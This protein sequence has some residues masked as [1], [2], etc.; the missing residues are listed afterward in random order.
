MDGRRWLPRP[1]AGWQARN[2]QALFVDTT[3]GLSRSKRSDEQAAYSNSQ[4]RGQLVSL[5]G[6][7]RTGRGMDDCY[8]LLFEAASDCATNAPA[9]KRPMP[10]EARH[11]LARLVAALATAPGNNRS[12]EQRHS[13]L[14]AASA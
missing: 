6:L 5:A 4:E 13:R 11:Q 10:G 2:V 3:K 14:G 8:A 12:G 7:S 9:A 1:A